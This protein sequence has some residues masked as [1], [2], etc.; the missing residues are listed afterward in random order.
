[1]AYSEEESPMPNTPTLAEQLFDEIKKHPGHPDSAAYLKAMVDPT[2]PVFESDYLDFKTNPDNDSKLKEMWYEALSGFGNSGGGV[3]IWGI[4]AHNDKTT[5]ID[6]ACAVEPVK[7]PQALK[8]RLIELQRGATDPPLGSVPIETWET[9][10]G[11]LS[12]SRGDCGFG[13]GRSG[14]TRVASLRNQSKREAPLLIP[15]GSSWSSRTVT[16]TR[17]SENGWIA[18]GQARKST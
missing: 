1:M 7:N 9:S 12:R 10:P 18:T 15:I 13:K 3:L 16:R 2:A 8:S 4:D 11:S 14:V 6:A 17:Q 5:G